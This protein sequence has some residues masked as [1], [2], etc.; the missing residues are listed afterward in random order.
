LTPLGH[1]VARA[2]VERLSS[3]ITAARR[4][5]KGGRA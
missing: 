2:E 1:A 4:L 3:Q 5:F